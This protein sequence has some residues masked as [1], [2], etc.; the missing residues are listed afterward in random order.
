MALTRLRYNYKNSCGKPIFNPA[1]IAQ[2]SGYKT[3]FEPPAPARMSSH[4]LMKR[5]TCTSALPPTVAVLFDNLQ[6][7]ASAVKEVGRDMRLSY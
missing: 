1:M 5:K 4:A 7:L 2:S 6:R 3:P